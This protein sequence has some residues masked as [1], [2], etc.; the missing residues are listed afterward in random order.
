M[1]VAVHSLDEFQHHLL[2]LMRRTDRSAGD[3]GAAVLTLAGGLLWL[4]DSGPVEVHTRGGGETPSLLWVA[5]G[6]TRYAVKYDAHLRRLEVRSGSGSG[7]LLL[8]VADETDPA[9]VLA[10]LRRLG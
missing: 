5:L 4:K 10:F 8:G 3:V 7:E 1:A 6:G 2:R 9:E